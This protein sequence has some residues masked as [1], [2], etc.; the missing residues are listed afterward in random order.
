MKKQLFIVGTLLLLAC[1]SIHAQYSHW[2]IKAKGGVNVLRARTSSSNNFFDRTFNPTFGADLEYT[3]TPTFGLGLEYSY[4]G[5]NQPDFGFDSQVHQALLIS[6][7]N[8]SNLTM[9]Y[10]KGIW[11]NLNVYVNV[12][13]GLGFGNWK[14]KSGLLSGQSDDVINLGYTFGPSIEYNLN[15]SLAIGVEGSYK[16]FSNGRFNDV[17]LDNNK[18]FYT[19][20]LS[21]RYKIPCGARTHIRNVSVVEYDFAHMPVNNSNQE[22]L[23]GQIDSLKNALA[24]VAATPKVINQYI[25]K[26]TVA[27]T[28]EKP[29]T[30]DSTKVDA[31]RML[32]GTRRASY[33]SEPEV[34]DTTKADIQMKTESYVNTSL[35]RYSVVV[36]SFMSKDN[37]DALVVSLKGQG[38]NTEVV[39]NEQG[40]NRVVIFT[41]NSSGAAI[42]QAKKVRSRFSGAWV[43]I[44][45]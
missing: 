43:M 5:N 24:V 6:S 41:S 15:R 32:N 42:A 3:L 31:G 36:G 37:A 44:L 8:L 27:K 2:S 11:T 25:M 34:E 23:Q 7:F 10:R 45:K 33:V 1:S 18:G 35:K 13:G 19:A 17:Q 9:K 4:L 28:K 21:F 16:W 29:I 40:L 12:G 26:D 38:Y 22:K 30:I 20:E 39:Q 14:A